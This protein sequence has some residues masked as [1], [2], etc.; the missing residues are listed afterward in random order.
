V[1]GGGLYVV[2]AIAAGIA[3]DAIV[4]AFLLAALAAA[5]N[6]LSSAA[7]AAKFPS[8]GGTY[9]YGYQLLSPLAG[10][11]A[12]WLF[13]VSKIAA[14]GT[15]ALGLA[16]YLAL[17]VPAIH[18]RL[19]ATI[20]V[21]LFTALNL[22]GIRK[23]SRANLAIVTI[24]LATLITFIILGFP[25]GRRSLELGRNDPRSLLQAAALLFFAF[26]GYARV[27]TLGEEVADP[28]RTIPRA[29]IATVIIS[30]ILYVAVATVTLRVIDPVVLSGTRAPLAAA[31]SIIGGSGLAIAV[32]AGAISAMF[33][34][35]LSQLL[36]L[37]RMVLAMARRGDLP[38]LLAHVDERRGVP[39]YAI[40]LVGAC[41]TLLAATGALA[42]LASTASCAILLYY[43]VA[44]VAALRLSRDDRLVPRYVALTGAVACLALAAS[45]PLRSIA[46]TAAALV[47]GFALR[48]LMRR[49]A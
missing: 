41:A 46:L 30:T 3:G 16:D 8:S 11:A 39:D 48:A 6:A 15:V 47:I 29:I 44:N 17:V 28:Q 38:A 23:S 10:F 24:T 1:V 27:A 14:A 49:Q 36:G 45:L 19:V 26:T 20:A 25:E 34:V 12:G 9:E 42:S 2:M 32:S 13:L 22:A 43:L 4:A 31:A 33:G 40:L 18:P 5:C 7:L 37:S 21:V 35:I